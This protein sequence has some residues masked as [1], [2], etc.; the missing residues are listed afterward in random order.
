MAGHFA[1]FTRVPRLHASD[2]GDPLSG[3]AFVGRQPI[4]DRSLTVYGY[5]LLYRRMHADTAVFNDHDAASAEVA[6]DAFLEFGLDTLVADR[7]A[8]INVSRD[9]LLSGFCWQLPADRV[10]LEILE[11]IDCDEAV[12]RAVELLAASGYRVALDDFVQDDERTPLLQHA[13]VV[14]LDAE[15]CGESGLRELLSGLRASGVDCVVERV[16]TQEQFDQCA[17]FG[18]TH[19]QGFFFARP[20]TVQG[21]R[22]PVE[23]LTALRVLALLANEHTSL[24]LLAEAVAADVR[25][26][27]QVLRAVNAAD[28]A[29]AVPVQSMP[30][31]IMRL[32]RDRLR[33]WLSV[34]AL[35]GVEGKPPAVLALA[36]TRA[37]M[38]EEL[39]RA[40]GA[41]LPGAWFL[42]GLFSTLDL[43]FNASPASLLAGL[44]LSPTIIDA[45]VHRS[46]DLG[47]AIDA[48]VA[49]EQ[50]QWTKARHGHLTPRDFTFAF[51]G[52][53]QWTREWEASAA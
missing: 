4:F 50:G 27:Y 32:G 9:V 6:L 3:S 49:F 44:P 28:S 42:G 20:T 5:E 53:L 10:V 18:A 22:V 25:L 21:R 47:A 16:E 24:G 19:F 46:G 51:R 23:R 36:L 40:S 48:V 33:G 1:A 2:T 7:R 8:F 52:A 38:C 39:G 37:R 29:P 35:S 43:L 17:G 31:A 13:A 30:D 11:G 41:G 12:C 45:V 34:M 15:A 14:K 26:A